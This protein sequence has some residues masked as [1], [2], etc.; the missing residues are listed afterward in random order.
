MQ[1]GKGGRYRKRIRGGRVGE[2]GRKRRGR[3]RGKRI[4]VEHEG[5]GKKCRKRMGWG[6]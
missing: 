5:G 4:G 6:H 3:A 1:R 2:K